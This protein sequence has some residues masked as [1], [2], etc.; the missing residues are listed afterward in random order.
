[1]KKSSATLS[2]RRPDYH[3][4][5]KLPALSVVGKSRFARLLARALMVA[6]IL[7]MAGLVVLPWQQTVRGTGRVIAFDPLDRRVEVEA[8]VA[9]RVRRLT[10]VEGQRVARGDVIAEIQDNDSNL[11]SNLEG[12][13]TAVNARI[14][15]LR[16]RIADLSAQIEQQRSAQAPAI[17]AAEQRIAAEKITA[18]TARINFERTQSLATAGL[19]SQRDLELAIQLRDSSAAQLAAVTAQRT[20]T[21]REFN[22]AIARVRADRNQSQGDLAVAERELGSAQISVNQAQQQTVVAPRDGIV[23]RV[24]VTDGT[25]LRPGSPI[26]VIIPESDSRFAELWLSGND[27]PLVSPRQTRP[28]GTTVPG[29]AVRMR[30]EGWPAIQFVGWPSVAVGTFGGEVVFV[31]ATDDGTGRFRVVVAPKPDVVERDGRRIE[32]GWPSNQWLRQGAR[33]DGWVLLQ[34]VPLWKEA[35]RQFNAFPPIVANKEPE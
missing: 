15:A 18:Q 9:G 27:V 29:S 14:Q 19:V 21:E 30:F 23:F 4:V 33:A 28:D 32:Q 6:V 17:A 5:G 24:S 8:P 1:M 3:W 34:Q 11:I 35:W 31:D 13:R 22:A 12:Q 25:F 20:Q 2:S 10:V 7:A 26:A 16:E